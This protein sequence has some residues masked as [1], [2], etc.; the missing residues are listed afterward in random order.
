MLQ[1]FCVRSISRAQC[2]KNLLWIFRCA[3]TLQN[4]PEVPLRPLFLNDFKDV[5]RLIVPGFD[6]SLNY[7]A[8]KAIHRV[9]ENRAWAP[10]D[11]KLLALE[12]GPKQ[13]TSSQ[14]AHHK[15]CSLNAVVSRLTELSIPLHP[16]V[17]HVGLQLSA[18]G[19][20]PQA[21]SR[22]ARLGQWHGTGASDWNMAQVRPFALILERIRSEMLKNK[23]K[24]WNSQRKREELL[25]L[26]TSPQEDGSFSSLYFPGDPLLRTVLIPLV[27]KLGGSPAVLALWD[28]IKTK[29]ELTRSEYPERYHRRFTVRDLIFA[30]FAN[31]DPKSAWGLANDSTLTQD[32]IIND[33]WERLLDHPELCPDWERVP[34]HWRMR[35]ALK[36][37]RKAEHE[38][39]ITWTGGENGKHVWQNGIMG[40]WDELVKTGSHNAEGKLDD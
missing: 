8:R 15:L 16:T 39:G 11:C 1:R 17:A 2:T 36:F 3:S 33:V 25:A 32:E 7:D 30:L 5:A 13:E 12:F 18:F 21:L 35:K 4:G 6:I 9:I 31:N 37:L 22:Y 26:L 20:S 38:L 19:P 14:E 29:W 34:E 27:S 10:G 24:D 28:Q 23:S 40:E